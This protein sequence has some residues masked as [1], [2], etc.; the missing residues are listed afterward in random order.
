MLQRRKTREV[1]LGPHKIGGHHPILVQSMTSTLTED[2]E[3]TLAQIRRLEEAGCE[4]VRVAC[5]NDA[6]AANLS[7]IKKAIRI[8]LIADIHFSHRLA[9]AAIAAGVDKVRL[10]PG[11]IGGKKK[12]QEV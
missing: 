6:S 4:A 9:L 5:P 3:A 7:A 2:L 1:R 11:N 8:P 12:V 10:N